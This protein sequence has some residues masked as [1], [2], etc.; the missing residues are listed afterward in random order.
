MRRIFLKRIAGLAALALP[1]VRQ[2]EA[3]GMLDMMI[4]RRAAAQRG[5]DEGDSGLASDDG[6]AMGPFD[7]PAGAR[8]E[9]DLAYGSDPAQRLD[10][11]L[12]AKAE[13]A[14]IIFMVH[15]GAWR[16]GNKALW[17]VVK[18][19]V[20]HWVGK[21]YIF[22]STNYPMLPAADP[23][24]QADSVA[25]AL[26]FVQSKLRSWGGD[27]ARLVVMGHSSGAHLVALLV[28][29]SSISAGQGVAPWFA[30][31][32]LDSAAMDVETIMRRR[33]FRFYDQAFKQDPAYWRQAS[34][35]HRLTGK[36]VTPLLIVCSS[37]RADSCPQGRALAAKATGFG[38]RADVLPVALTHPEVNDL[39][40]TQSTY[41]DGV[42]GFLKSL[43]LQ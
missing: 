38:G 6:R 30:T 26:A 4:I 28:A 5:M 35:I 18:N 15:G 12:P 34:P 43:G 9:R 21:G 33:H 27:P 40:G 1:A 29:D 32:A 3:G 31:V 13:R 23:L 39:L 10:V 2:I 24:T 17:R 11:Y 41:T 42:D 14:P 36:P 20:A 8:V 22:V 25:K 37:R 7:L 16:Q 19:K